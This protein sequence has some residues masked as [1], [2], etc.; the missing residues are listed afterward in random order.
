[1]KSI[2]CFSLFVPV[3]LPDGFRKFR[4]YWTKKLIHLKYGHLPCIG[5]TVFFMILS[6]LVSIGSYGVENSVMAGKNRL[7]SALPVPLLKTSVEQISVENLR[8][9]D[10]WVQHYE[11]NRN[12]YF[13]MNCC[14]CPK[15][16]RSPTLCQKTGH[17]TQQV[18][19]GCLL[20]CVLGLA[21]G[22]TLGMAMTGG[23]MEWLQYLAAV[24]GIGPLFLDSF[25]EVVEK[26]KRICNKQEQVTCCDAVQAVPA[27]LLGIGSGWLDSI[28][29]EL[30]A[31]KL[32]Q[33]NITLLSPQTVV[34]GWSLRIGNLLSSIALYIFGFKS[35][36][37]C[38]SQRIHGLYSGV[39]VE[40]EQET[41]KTAFRMF[42]DFCQSLEDDK[43]LVMSPDDFQRIS[44]MMAS[45]RYNGIAVKAFIDQT[46]MVACQDE[47]EGLLKQSG[48]AAYR[49]Q[50]GLWL[51]GA[52]ALY[53]YM[54]N[55][56][57]GAF[58]VPK[59]LSELDLVSHNL[60]YAGIL[61]ANC[62][63]VAL[64]GEGF[65]DTF[66]TVSTD[67]IVG[68][69]SYG[70]QSFGLTPLVLA[71]FISTG[72]FVMPMMYLTYLRCFE[73][74]R[75]DEWY[76]SLT[77]S[78][79]SLEYVDIAAW[80]SSLLGVV[81]YL[82]I[83]SGGI[84]PAMVMGKLIQC[85]VKGIHHL[86]FTEISPQASMPVLAGVLLNS[87]GTYRKWWKQWRSPERPVDTP[88]LV[89]K[90]IEESLSDS[91]SSDKKDETRVRLVLSSNECKENTSCLKKM[92]NSDTLSLPENY[93]VFDEILGA[94]NSAEKFDPSVDTGS[95]ASQPRDSTPSASGGEK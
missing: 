39:P 13:G 49:L 66:S 29:M 30:V 1:M 11:N 95:F 82:S 15:T 24:I 79:H 48:S 92:D 38:Y 89:L 77:Y 45:L 26:L 21:T 19:Y 72:T 69:F 27:C 67:M 32:T 55:F 73:P 78:L 56:M 62:S 43:T 54:A 90:D 74:E 10:Q 52:V 46:R 81:G 25:I 34:L 44:V 47:E 37:Q 5:V 33:E 53:V 65:S 93:V 76:S 36:F 6:L 84:L 68:L 94:A 60:T 9:F 2:H 88:D 17:R 59:Y 28:N 63:T 16:E 51:M 7:T 91:I 4:Y 8:L 86:A 31:K 75:Y 83:I 18:L 70:I 64:L 35:I 80:A 3:M 57:T 14:C 85:G 71:M 23:Y 22:N 12:G 87:Q 58:V 40:E 50:C 42:L 61:D 20:F 41:L